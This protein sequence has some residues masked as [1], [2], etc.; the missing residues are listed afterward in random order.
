MS[1]TLAKNDETANSFL[2]LGFYCH[3]TAIEV[4]KNFRVS[5]LSVDLAEVHI[6]LIQ[7]FF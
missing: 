1:V 3:Q 7:H 4:S 6:F 5:F 2:F